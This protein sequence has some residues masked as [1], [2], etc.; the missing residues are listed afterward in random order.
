M[1]LFKKSYDGYYLLL[2]F[3]WITK[4]KM[5]I[6]FSMASSFNSKGQCYIEII[7]HDGHPTSIYIP[8]SLGR[9]RSIVA[10]F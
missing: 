6:E 10:M 4:P 8:T 3:L 1:N 5:E 2:F 7:F 9:S